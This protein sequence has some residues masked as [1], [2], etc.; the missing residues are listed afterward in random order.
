MEIDNYH[1]LDS[2]LASTSREGRP[3]TRYFI[4]LIQTA[5]A[6]AKV[7]LAIQA[8]KQGF[9]AVFAQFKPFFVISRK[10]SKIYIY[11]YKLK[12]D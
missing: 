8:M 6:E 3:P 9:Y 11:I 7:F 12:T 10:N 5:S 2:H 4:L 1:F